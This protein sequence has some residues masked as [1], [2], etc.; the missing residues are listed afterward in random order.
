MQIVLHGL[1]IMD[2]HTHIA[3]ECFHEAPSVG[4]AFLAVANDHV[5]IDQQLL[6]RRPRAR[7]FGT[8]H[9]VRG[10]E[11]AA[12]RVL[13]GQLADQLLGRTQIHDR[14]AVGQVVEHVGQ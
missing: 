14:P 5:F 3:Q 10:Y 9:R 6:E 4:I 2:F 8:G 11:L 12:F 1:H 7:I 13:V